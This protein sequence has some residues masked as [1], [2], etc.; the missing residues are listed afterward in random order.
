MYRLD[1][2]RHATGCSGTATDQTSVE[3]TV[4]GNKIVKIGNGFLSWH[5][6]IQRDVPSLLQKILDLQQRYQLQGSI[7]FNEI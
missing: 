7:L 3:I 2:T 5:L 4:A 6:M 1:L